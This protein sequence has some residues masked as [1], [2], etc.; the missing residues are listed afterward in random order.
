M[1]YYLL[2]QR[3]FLSQIL[4]FYIHVTSPLRVPFIWLSGLSLPELNCHFF[5]S[6]LSAIASELWYTRTQPKRDISVSTYRSLVL[7]PHAGKKQ[8][9]H[10]KTS[11]AETDQQTGHKH[12]GGSRSGNA[13]GLHLGSAQIEYGPGHPPSCLKF[14]WFSSVPPIKSGI[15]SRLHNESLLPN[16][17]QFVVNHPP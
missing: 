15:V 4:S 6:F 16:P 2:T 1:P 17:L 14:S 7:G 10:F 3:T 5:S 13:P 9:R 12:R 8:G 11:K